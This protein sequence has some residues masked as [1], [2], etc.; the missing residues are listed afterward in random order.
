MSADIKKVIHVM[1]TRAVN[2]D[3]PEDE[4]FLEV[5]CQGK[6]ADIKEVLEGMLQAFPA[7]SI[8]ACTMRVMS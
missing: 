5:S 8:V 6:S 4:Q 7:E 2:V 1:T 3:D